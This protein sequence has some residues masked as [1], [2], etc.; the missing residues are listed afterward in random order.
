MLLGIAALSPSYELT[1]SETADGSRPGH[2][3][4]AF[5]QA[6]GLFA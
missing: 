2:L 5:V 4:V 1:E 6:F 3:Q